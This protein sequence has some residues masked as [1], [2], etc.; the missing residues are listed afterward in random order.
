[1]QIDELAKA[2]FSDLSKNIFEDYYLL[3]SN[4]PAKDEYNRPLKSCY[5]SLKYQGEDDHAGTQLVDIAGVY[6]VGVAAVA[7]DDAV[8]D[9]E[10]GGKNEYGEEELEPNARF[11]AEIVRLQLYQVVRLSRRCIGSQVVLVI[12]ASQHIHLEIIDAVGKEFHLDGKSQQ[13]GFHFFGGNGIF[14]RLGIF[15]AV[16]QVFIGKHQLREYDPELKMGIERESMHSRQAKTTR[17][18]RIYG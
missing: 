2:L 1:M 12:D 9:L 16:G 15:N 3:T 18:E 6:E 5:L 14:T 13:D 11:Y 8:A 10:L 7:V 4:E 17:I